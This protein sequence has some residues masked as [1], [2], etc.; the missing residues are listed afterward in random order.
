MK[1]ILVITVNWLGDSI[2]TT[3]AFK[4]LKDK[5]PASYVGV[6]AVERVRAVFD[7]NPY[8]DEVIVF[9]EKKKSFGAKL[10]FAR[11]LKTKH[12][13]TVFLIHRSFTRAS[14][15]WLAG[16]K[17]RIG[18]ARPKNLFVLT[19]RIKPPHEPIHRQDY[20]LYLFEK[21]GIPL[22]QRL[23]QFFI[24]QNTRTKT[25][26]YLKTLTGTYSH[27]VGMNPS[28]NWDLKRWPKEN[29]ARLADRLMEELN[30][31]VIFVGAAANA[32]YIEGVIEKMDNKP[33]NMCGKTNLKELAALI[34]QTE[35]FISNDSGPAH[36]AAA[37]KVPLLV[38]FGPTS[39]QQ[40]SPRGQTVTIIRE[41][42]KCETP[43]YKLN[44]EDNICM[45]KIKVEDVFQK[46]KEHLEK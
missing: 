6:L 15:C 45:K 12:F 30:C 43:C 42:I 10:E 40:T 36:L 22:P 11:R 5:F 24:P 29:F 2:L 28:A 19:R 8:I 4:A 1:R 16:I 3:A 31:A 21:C 44:C 26:E 46:A 38:L 7:N 32:F 9:D 33:I 17:Q 35:L 18:Y 14:I 23:P 20:Y 34:E 25:N 13:D 27:V 41:D 37:L 39:P